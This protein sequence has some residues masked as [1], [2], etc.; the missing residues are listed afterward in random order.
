MHVHMCSS[1]YTCVYIV[2]ACACAHSVAN[3]RSCSM[4]IKTSKWSIKNIYF[5]VLISKDI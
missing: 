3:V 1:M 4:C 2:Y 5:M